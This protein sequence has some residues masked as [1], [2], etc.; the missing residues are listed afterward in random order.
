MSAADLGVL[1]AGSILPR[2]GYGCAGYVLFAGGAP[3]PGAEAGEVTLLDLGPGSVRA[4]AAMGVSLAGVR[5]VVL[6]H[7]HPDHCLDLFALAFAR[8]SPRLGAPAPIELVGPVGLRALLA[9]APATFGG[10]ARDPNARVTEVELDAGERGLFRAG[11]LTF[12]CT[13]NGHASTMTTLSWRVDADAGWSLLYTGDTNEDE[14]VSALGRGVD[15]FVAECSFPEEEAAPNHLTPAS[16]ARLAASAGA[17][18]LLL[19][20]FYPSNDPQAAR[21]RASLGFDGPVEIARD[22]SVHRIA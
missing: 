9:E 15:L 3:R 17:K 12:R 13:R 5:R 21:E 7:F 14:R 4:L 19:S 16:A 10:W 8:R 2:D 1:G 11:S 22:G 6:S 18:R 20:H